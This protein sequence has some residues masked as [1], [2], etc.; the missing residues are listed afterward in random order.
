M[1]EFVE[2]VIYINL[3]HRIDRKEHI[4]REL[5]KVFPSEK[6]LRF[7]AI[8]DNDGQVGCISSHIEVLKLAIKN[9]WKNCLV[10]E[11]DMQWVDIENGIS[12]LSKIISN[13]YDVIVLGGTCINLKQDGR[14]FDCQT[15]T[16]FI[17][18]NHYYKTLL[19]TFEI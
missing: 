10:V 11:D 9:D 4:E 14:L 19:Q 8:R 1:F 6:V 15:T 3:T 16:A 7:N 12:T 13:P 2:K 18:N 5:L 17:V